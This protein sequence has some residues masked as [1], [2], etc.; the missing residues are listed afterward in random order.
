MSDKILNYILLGIKSLIG[1]VGV[2]LFVMILLGEQ[3]SETG[4]KLHATGAIDGGIV[5]SYIVSVLC[6]V[7][8]IVF[9]IWGI[10]SNFKKSL[11]MLASLGVFAILF[12]IS[13]SMASDEIMETWKKKPDLFTAFNVKWSDVGIYIMY[14]MLIMTVIAI[15]VSEIVKLFK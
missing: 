13:Y 10:A 3:T 11:P 12:L 1:V 4:E 9:A 2:I 7:L 15:V 14:F 5:L 6:I 8:W